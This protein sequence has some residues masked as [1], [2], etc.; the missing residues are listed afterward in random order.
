MGE[1]GSWSSNIQLPW[2]WTP[3][4]QFKELPSHSP[5]Y[6][7]LYAIYLALKEVKGPLNLFS[8]SVYAVNL[9]PWLSRSFIK[10]D[11]NPL[12]PLLI[13]V[14]TLLQERDAPIYIQHVWLHSPLPGP[15]SQRNTLADQ[16]ASREIFMASTEQADQ[17]HSCTHT[18][19][20]GLQVHFPHI[21]LAQLQRIIKTCS[22]CASLI[23]TP[24]LQMMSTNSLG[25]KSNALWQ[26]DVTHIPQ[27]GRQKYVFVTIDTYSHFIW[28]T[29]QTGENS[30]RLIHHMLSTFA[31]MGIPQQIKTDNGRTFTSY[32]FYTFCTH[33]EIA[34]HM[35]IPHNP[36][37][38]GIIE[39]TH[40]TLKAQLLKQKATTY[41]PNVQLMMALTTLNIFN[42]YKNSKH[43]P[44]SLHCLIPKLALP[45]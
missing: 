38:Q 33:S 15:I 36:Q 2:G 12:S 31:I 6:K 45:S 37:G 3:I 28:A 21:P 9:L 30:K 20:K 35:G 26:I 44:I 42:I 18:N 29:A 10:L 25:L 34:H 16:T 7:E 32:Q 11:A 4:L 17:F 14:S 19:I 5:Q 27:F 22:S 24:A 39:R 8:D 43:P 1:K 41:P 23:T 13:Q 40:Q